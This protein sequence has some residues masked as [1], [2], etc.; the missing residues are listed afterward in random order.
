MDIELVDPELR[1]L[2]R[3]LPSLNPGNPMVRTV[4]RVAIRLMRPPVT[5]T[6]RVRTVV[7]AGR[8]ARVY[9]PAA[10]RT[11]GA[12]LWIHGGGLLFGD[13]KQDERICAETARDVGVTVVSV[14][15]RV[16]PEHP[17]PAAHD[18]VLAAWRWLLANAASLGVDP[19][20]IIVGGE[21]AGGGLAAALVHRIHDDGGTQPV[22]QWLFAPMIDDST[23][24]DRSLDD[25]DHWVWN[26]RLNRMGWSG[27]LPGTYGTAAV[28]EYAA[29]ARRPDLSGL[30][31]AY[32]AVGDIELF[33]AE[34][35]EYARRLERAGVPTTLDV[36]AGAPHGFENW[37]ADTAPARSLMGRARAWMT[38]IFRAAAADSPR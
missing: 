29:A 1:D 10:R 8:R 38:E 33:S 24:A 21:S 17:F 23:A 11:S 36:V 6:V 32:L 20:Q 28:P 2:T 16:A 9:E 27:Y 35:V 31:P 18:D 19:A 26:N 37:A 12:L 14:N 5:P 13:A 4:M 15:Y 22:G 25:V 34:N 30:A 7:A 3:R